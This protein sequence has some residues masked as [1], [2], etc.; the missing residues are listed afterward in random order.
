MLTAIVITAVLAQ[1]PATADPD[2]RAKAQFKEWAKLNA[3]A[4][5]AAQKLP[6]VK[7]ARAYNA[8][9]L[10]RNQ[11]F[12][13][14]HGLTLLQVESLILKGAA[15]KWPAEDEAQAKLVADAA[16]AIKALRSQN[17]SMRE[18]AIFEQEMA[19]IVDRM[20][21]ERRALQPR[22]SSIAGFKDRIQNAPPSITAADISVT[23]CGHPTDD[24]NRC[25]RKVAGGGYCYQH[26]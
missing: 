26:R 2:A 17:D 20:N 14:K 22:T 4:V 24:G 16:A 13:K 8:S 11:E 18:Q 19:T 23:T 10:K 6:K 21:R 3:G 1:A 25:K 15:E 12:C 7:R 9:L 5:A